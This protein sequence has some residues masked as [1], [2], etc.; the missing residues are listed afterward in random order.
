MN[1]SSIYYPIN[2]VAVVPFP[3][4]DIKLIILINQIISAVSIFSCLLVIIMYWFF[5]EIRNFIIELSI[6]LC[7]CYSLYNITAFFPYENEK[8]E[9]QVWCGIQSFMIAMFQNSCWIWSCI[10]GYSCFISAVKKNH[11]ENNKNVYRIFFV[12]L[13]TVIPA[14]LA[15]V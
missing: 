11:I 13:A 8:S 4:D 12:L 3:E 10:I 6:W 14:A 5:K 1:N 7:I 2:Y 9:N 15:S